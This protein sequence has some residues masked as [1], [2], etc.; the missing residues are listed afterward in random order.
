[1]APRERETMDRYVRSTLWV[2]L[3]V[4]AAFAVAFAF[5]VQPA[6]DLWPFPGRTFLTNLFIGSIFAA[7]AASTAWCLVVR[8]DRAIAGIAL[9]YIT[10]FVP[11]AIFSF[12]QVAGGRAGSSLHVAAFGVTSAIGVGVG[13]WLLR[14]SLAQPWRDERP[15]PR[16]VR[17]SF[18]VFIVALVIVSGLLIGRVPGILPWAITPELSI[19]IGFMVLGAAAYFA[20]G[21][22]EPRWENAGGQLAGFLAYD[23]VLIGPFVQRMP[24]IDDEFRLNLIVYTAVLVYSGALALYYLAL[25]PGTRGRPPSG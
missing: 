9:D 25:H 8:S 21:V 18:V 2:V 13:L 1:M 12:A 23:L 11:F 15:T 7:A 24:S 19:L 16:L 20:Y 14:W 3:A 5:Q 17:G 6:I 4:Q 22:I 10:I